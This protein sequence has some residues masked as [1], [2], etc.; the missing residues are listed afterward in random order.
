MEN[1]SIIIFHDNI[2][3]NK[4]W[5]DEIIKQKNNNNSYTI[6]NIKGSNNNFRQIIQNYNGNKEKE[7]SSLFVKN[8]NK[9]MKI[10]LLELSG[11]ESIDYSFNLLCLSGTVTYYFCIFQ[12]KLIYR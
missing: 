6:E 4:E 7:L 2:F 8:V 11:I 1:K 10:N 12:G 3:S 9:D 5:S